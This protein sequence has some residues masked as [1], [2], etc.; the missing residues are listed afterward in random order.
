MNAAKAVT[1]DIDSLVKMCPD[2]PAEENGCRIEHD[3]ITILRELRC[4][5]HVYPGRGLLRVSH[6]K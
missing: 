1:Y 6:M 3:L 4:C 5:F 2:C